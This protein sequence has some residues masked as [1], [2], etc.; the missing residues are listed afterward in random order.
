MKKKDTKKLVKII[1]ANNLMLSELT[2]LVRELIK[3]KASK[4]A[5]LPPLFNDEEE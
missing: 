3:S 1:K 2:V 4:P 5:K